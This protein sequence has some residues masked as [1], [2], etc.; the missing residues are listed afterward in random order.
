[1]K[2]LNIVIIV[3]SILIVFQSCK[4]DHIMTQSGKKKVRIH[5]VRSPCEDYTTP[6]NAVRFGDTLKIIVECSDCG[7]WGGHK[8]SLTIQRYNDTNICVRFK[9]DTVN[10]HKIVE[11]N[12]FGVLDEKF[13]GIVLD[14]T[15]IITLADEKLISSFLQRLLELYLKNE[16]HSN[17]GTD[18]TVST[19]KSKFYLS[20]WNSGDCRDT[21]YQ[22]VRKQLFGKNLRLD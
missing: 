17:A 14:T 5:K 1:M 6:L 13:R 4:T 20:F 18:Y 19:S 7:E 8:E 22:K 11:K 12:G 10:C 16:M 9:M 2:Y 15:K 3:F 21:Y